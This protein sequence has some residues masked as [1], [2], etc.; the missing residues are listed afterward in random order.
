MVNVVINEKK[1]CYT[2]TIYS[3]TCS[4]TASTIGKHPFQCYNCYCLIHGKSSPLLRKYHRRNQLKYPHLDQLWA[5]KSGVSHKYCSEMHLESAIKHRKD[6][7]KVQ[8]S[9]NIKMTQRIQ[10][11]LQESWYQCNSATPFLKTLHA[12]IEENKS[13]SFDMSFIQN[14]VQKKA[15]GQ[16]CRADAQ[17][18]A[19]A[20]LYSNRLGEKT[21]SKL[22]PI[23]ALPRVWQAQRLKQKE[24]E[25]EHYMPGIN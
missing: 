17:A 4:K 19:L 21:Y 12:L 18:R 5:T 6:T 25:V 1:T 11:M 2:G 9:K 16:Y 20:V 13:S 23:L 7:S 15:H 8:K 14:W 22:A 24:C 3:T 10:D